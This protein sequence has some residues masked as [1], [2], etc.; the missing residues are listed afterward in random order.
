MSLFSSVKKRKT[1]QFISIIVQETHCKIKQKI[2]KNKDILHVE[3]Y[4]YDIPSKENLGPKV[5]QF[6]INLQ[7]EY[8]NTYIA[9]FLNTLGQGVIPVCDEDE[10]QKYH[11]DKSR[12]KSICVDQRFLMYATKADINWADK[13][14]KDIGLDFV[15]SPFLVLDY[16]IQKEELVE[17]QV[18]LHI[19]NTSNALT[20]MINRGT[21][22][23]YG[24]FFNVAKEENLLYTDYS[25]PDDETQESALDEL[26]LEEDELEIDEIGA[27]SD[28]SN[29]VNNVLKER[30]RL[31]EQDERV[32]KY[33]RT[34]L[35]EFYANSLYESDFITNAKIYDAAGMDE[36]VMNYIEN[37]LLLDTNAVN[38]SVR[39]AIL[40]LSKQEVMS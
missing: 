32:I 28:N 6:L 5:N 40:E 3:E 36:G 16:Y 13:A 37:E 12:V 18:T 25:N 29:F 1:Q 35:K 19:L 7:E 38:I 4:S 8:D 23:L 26:D 30:A 21:K 17:E 20:I 15:F 24:S 39:D 2:V 9:L 27:I 10:L 11:I 22:L 14:F 31:S 33:L 34:A